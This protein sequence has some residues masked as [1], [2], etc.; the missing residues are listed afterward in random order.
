VANS[1][2]LGVELEWNYEC[3]NEIEAEIG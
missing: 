1:E 2:V 3:Y